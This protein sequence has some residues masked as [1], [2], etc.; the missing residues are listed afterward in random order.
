MSLFA[1][2]FLPTRSAQRQ[3]LVANPDA[4]FGGRGFAPGAGPVEPRIP[5]FESGA[6]GAGVMCSDLST[7]RSLSAGGG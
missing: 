2:D 1:E 7:D 5:G 6:T 3:P 4:K